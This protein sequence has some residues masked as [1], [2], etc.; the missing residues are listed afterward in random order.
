M[1]ETLLKEYELNEKYHDSKENRAWIACA[2]Y[3]TYS[4]ILLQ[5]I[6]N[7]GSRRIIENNGC[8]LEIMI[9]LID[10]SVFLFI[11]QQL[12]RK[13]NSVRKAAILKYAIVNQ[14]TNNEKIV[15]ST[16]VWKD[17]IAT[18]ENIEGYFPGWLSLY[19]I[20]LP[21]FFVMLLLFITKLF[22][23]LRISCYGWIMRSRI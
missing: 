19:F 16:I 11:F 22:L 17:E 20:E 3:F 1:K 10:I 18:K 14:Y 2:L 15:L 4:I 23:I 13:A 6:L 21:L 12:R 5:W 8:L 7:T 9:A